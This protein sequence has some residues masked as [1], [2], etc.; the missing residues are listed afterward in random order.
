MQHIRGHQD[1]DNT[2]EQLPVAAQANVIVDKRQKRNY[3]QITF[4]KT[5]P[6]KKRCGSC[7]VQD[8]ELQAIWKIDL[9]VSCRS[10]TL[11]D[12]GVTNYRYQKSTED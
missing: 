7:T 5:A 2:F 10:S 8:R 12:G 3:K 6:P 4:Q 1:D 11:N 9:D